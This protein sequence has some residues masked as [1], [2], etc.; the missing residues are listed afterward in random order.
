MPG[1]QRCP[2]FRYIANPGFIPVTLTDECESNKLE[3]LNMSPR[4][5]PI[6]ILLS[7][8]TP[9]AAD[10]LAD[11]HQAVKDLGRLNGVALHCKYLDQVRAMKAAVVANAPKQRSFGLAFDEGTNE[12]YLEQIQQR[13]PCPGKTAFARRVESATQQLEQ[14]FAQQ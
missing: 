6:L 5:W 3:I 13:A 8:S 2:L 1:L 14:A 4:L 10:M 9:V 12:A 7:F 11:Q